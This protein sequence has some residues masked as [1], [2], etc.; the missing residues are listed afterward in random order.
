[1]IRAFVL[2]QTDIGSV[3]KVAD[4]L[5]R[6]EGVE[7]AHEITG[8]YDII[9]QVVTLDLISLGESVTNAIQRIDGVTRTLTCPT[10]REINIPGDL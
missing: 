6:T 2:I 10:T 9:A 5:S 1:M 8:P 3:S 7:A 4:E